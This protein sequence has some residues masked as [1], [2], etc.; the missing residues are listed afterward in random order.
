[1]MDMTTLID[2][3]HKHAS[4]LSKF[5]ILMLEKG[6]PAF[7]KELGRAEDVIAFLFDCDIHL[8]QLVNC[9]RTC[10]LNSQHVRWNITLRR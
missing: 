1:M 8:W 4:G 10:V 6:K 2:N 5:S 9:C 3:I 7:M